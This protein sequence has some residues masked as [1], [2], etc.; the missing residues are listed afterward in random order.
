M[1]DYRYTA[2]LY[3]DG[4]SKGYEDFDSLDWIDIILERNPW[5]EHIEVIDNEIVEMI[6]EADYDN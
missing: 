6:M 5:I 1:N 2:W 4:Y 3:K